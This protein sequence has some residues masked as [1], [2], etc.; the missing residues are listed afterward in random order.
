MPLPTIPAL[1]KALPTI[2]RPDRD[3]TQAVPWA[4]DVLSLVERAHQLHSSSA[5]APNV[6]STDVPVGPVRIGDPQL[7]RLVDVALP[8][9]LEISSPQPA[10]SP[11][12][13]HVAEALYLRATCEAS[14]AYPQFIPHN[15]RTAFRDF[16]QAAKNGFYAA[17]FKLG[18]D[19]ENFGDSGHAKDCFERGVKYGVESCLYVSLLLF[20]T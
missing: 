7:Q 11:M 19:Y 6:N 20:Q 14:G 8:I 16:E 4:R 2:Q 13:P 18:R 1:T 15:P 3:P 17:W 5:N 9:I 10:P 12:P